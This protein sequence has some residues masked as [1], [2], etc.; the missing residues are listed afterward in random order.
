[1]NDQTI[2]STLSSAVGTI[3]HVIAALSRAEHGDARDLVARA[4]GEL[5]T[6]S[7]ELL[8]LRAKLCGDRRQPVR[9][10]C[11]PCRFGWSSDGR[12]HTGRRACV[13]LLGGKR[14]ANIRQSVTTQTPTY[15]DATSLS[16]RLRCRELTTR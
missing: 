5:K 1:M 3:D 11:S 10:N 16:K 15:C 14:R 2:R 4:R 12:T 9:T 8:V 13:G 6:T 7:A